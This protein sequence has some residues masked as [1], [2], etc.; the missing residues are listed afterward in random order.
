MKK[1][2]AL[3]AVGLCLATGMS[4]AQEVNPIAQISQQPGYCTIIH[5]WGFIGDSLCSGEH[6]YEI[7]G[8]G[9]GYND[10]LEYSWGQRICAACGTTG[11][12]YSQGG[13]T[14]KGWI[15]NF[16]DYPC[17]RNK[18]IC[19]KTDLK[20]AYIIALGCNDKNMGLPSG[21]PYKDINL[22]DYNKNGDNF[23]GS[24]GGIIQRIKEVQP[25]AKFFIVTMPDDYAEESY[26]Q[27]LRELPN[28]FDNLYL[29]DIA[30]YGPSYKD[31]T[32]QKKYF[33]YGHMNAAGY[34]FTA[35]MFMTYINWIIE[36]NMSDFSRI[37]FMK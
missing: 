37:A 26:N 7:P 34:Q 20:Q 9:F 35:W 25:E 10:I 16:W 27:A 31:P 15:R 1:I 33:L 29:L 3:A 22:E 6:E 5:R 14:A 23:I 18:D 2:L 24:Y 32:F 8:G 12:N 4:S 19:A 30:K 11:D 28:I 36:N 13:E 21:D 17:N